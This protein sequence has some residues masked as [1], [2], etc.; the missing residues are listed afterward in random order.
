MK[1]LFVITKGTWGGATR[2]VYDLATQMD[3]QGHEVHVAYGT[4]GVLEKKL[5]LKNITHHHING[6]ERDI[7]LFKEIQALKETLSLLEKIS[8]DVLHINSSKAGMIAALSGRIKKT[9]NIIF[10]AHG[11]AFTERRNILTK[12]VFKFFYFLIL[13]LS[14]RTIAVSKFIEEQVK[15][16]PLVGKK[17]IHIPLGIEKI[18]NL[19]R[20]EARNELS[21]IKKIPSEKKDSFWVATIAELHDNKG[22]D[23]AISAMVRL[24]KEIGDNFAYFVFGEGELRWELESLIESYGLGNN[25]FLLGFV[26]DAAKYIPACNVFLLPSRTEALGYVLLE[27]G[28]TKTPAIATRVGGIPELILHEKTGLLVPE[29]SP[30]VIAEAIKKLYANEALRDKLSGA[31][32]EKIESE[33]TLQKMTEETEKLYS[34]QITP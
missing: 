28:L 14:H 7:G 26:P 1:I 16:W 13:L 10:T 23:T 2:Y 18:P 11:F 30:Y 20:K 9:P 4:K 15:N 5:Q 21:L 32:K 34:S 29:N 22:I 19:S 17:V 27:C 6:L 33:Y 8:P 31:L 12:Q 3:Q 24:K 25:V